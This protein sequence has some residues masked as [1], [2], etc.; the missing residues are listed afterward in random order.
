MLNRGRVST[1]P[2]LISSH[3]IPS[4]PIHRASAVTSAWAPL[5]LDLAS[6]FFFCLS[7]LEFSLLLIAWL[8]TQLGPSSR[9]TPL[10]WSVMPAL[11]QSQTYFSSASLPAVKGLGR[12]CTSL[13]WLRWRVKSVSW[14]F[15]REQTAAVICA[16]KGFHKWTLS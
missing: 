15:I 8:R 12:E 13:A 11:S 6:M 1:L 16:L 14:G 10:I 5:R 7:C 3:G 2:H 4:S 9:K